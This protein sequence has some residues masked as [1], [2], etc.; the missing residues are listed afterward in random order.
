MIVQHHHNR[1][2]VVK[3]SDAR[4]VSTTLVVREVG[5]MTLKD[6]MMNGKRGL[7][8]EGESA[9]FVIDL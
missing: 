5:E 2:K 6:R 1:R 4:G 3:R 9:L 7:P 8:H